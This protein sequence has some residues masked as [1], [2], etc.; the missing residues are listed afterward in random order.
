VFFISLTGLPRGDLLYL[1]LAEN[2]YISSR[3][4]KSL[5]DKNRISCEIVNCSSADALLDIAEKIAPDIVIIDFD[6]FLD[7]S[8]NIVKELRRH[9]SGAYILAFV[10]PDH[11]DRLHQAIDD[12]ID[13]YMVK[14]LQ[15]EDV[16]LRLKM[17]LQNH[18]SYSSSRIEDQAAVVEPVQK[19]SPV[20]EE[21][22]ADSKKMFED[23][24]DL[25]GKQFEAEVGQPDKTITK[26]ENDSAALVKEPDLREDASVIDKDLEEVKETR[27]VK[28]EDKDLELDDLL[29]RPEFDFSWPGKGDIS[30]GITTDAFQL[31][32]AEEPAAAMETDDLSLFGL[33]SK[34]DLPSAI[35]VPEES[36]DADPQE[37]SLIDEAFS[38]VENL[39]DLEELKQQ[40]DLSVASAP[41][42][43]KEADPVPDLPYFDDLFT[44]EPLTD[45]HPKAGQTPEKTVPSVAHSKQETV[46]EK[47]PELPEDVKPALDD[48]ELFGMS[49][50]ERAVDRSS[51]EELF[52]A[53]DGSAKKQKRLTVEPK[54][55]KGKEGKVEYLPFARKTSAATASIPVDEVEDLFKDQPVI[56]E[57]PKK[58]KT[59][60]Q[61]TAKVKQKAAP[62]NTEQGG[63][64][65]LRLAGNIITALLLIIMVGLSFFL[66]QSRINGGAPTIAGYQMYVVLSGSMNPAFDTGSVVFVKSTEPTEIV[67]GD[68][69]TFSS[70]GDATRLTTHRV[71]GINLSNGLNFITKGD[72]NNINDPSPVPAENVVGRVTGSVP[73]IGYLFGFAQTRQGLILLIFIPGLFLIIMELRRLF[74]YMVEAKVEQLKGS[75]PAE[76]VSKASSLVPQSS[77]DRSAL[78]GSGPDRSLE[79]FGF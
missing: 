32:S 38:L 73:Y 56:T 4:I 36:S 5:L 9:S 15:R 29:P 17:G 27:S 37:L 52:G 41:D 3:E 7:D 72:A 6:L 20:A 8:A 74:K 12:G 42:A 60:P 33:D 40:T 43:E 51:F 24:A 45:H 62:A 70:S 53:F 55:K 26:D 35:A 44:R 18:S 63:S 65:F 1:L 79:D 76:P 25:F 68:I 13:N 2:N 28:A 22:V 31:E 23:L 49:S 58:Q 50:A 16:L 11:Y 67:E 34:P 14:P 71:I 19:A 69:I 57:K 48:K 21:A 54:V 47:E 59:K 46:F 75:A 30:S 39:E 66:I 61:K 10:D 77:S 78:P 64:N